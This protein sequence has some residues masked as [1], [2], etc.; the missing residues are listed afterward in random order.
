MLRTL[1]AKTSICKIFSSEKNI[2]MTM[3]TLQENLQNV[4]FSMFQK[5]NEKR[6]NKNCDENKVYILRNKDKRSF[7][8]N[9]F[10]VRLSSWKYHNLNR[11]EYETKNEQIVEKMSFQQIRNALSRTKEQ[12]KL[13]REKK[14]LWK[15]FKRRNINEKSKQFLRLDDGEWIRFKNE[16]HV[17]T[18]KRFMINTFQKLRIL[19]YNV[20][21]SRNKMIIILL[22]EKRINN[23]NILIIQKLWQHHEETQTYNSRGINFTLKNNNE[24]TCFY[25]NNC[26]DDNNWH[27]TWHFKDVNIITLQLQQ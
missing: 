15:L 19:Q 18:K 24:K 14:T 9:N 6:K 22:H 5:I 3:R 21:K 23:Y 27:N 7:N 17:F 12:H 11:K 10:F 26:I 16:H 2:K 4:W 8:C 13:I 25:I 20:H 1:R